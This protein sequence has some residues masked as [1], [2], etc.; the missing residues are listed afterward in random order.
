MTQTLSH[1]PV[2]VAAA[3]HHQI[4]PALQKIEVWCTTAIPTFRVVGLPGPEIIESCERVRAAIASTGIEFPKKRVIV[5]LS[6]AGIR[7]HGT[8]TDLAIALA[9]LLSKSA[10]RPK[11]LVVASGELGL[12]GQITSAGKITRTILAAL[13]AGA[14]D[15]LLALDDKNKAQTAA[16]LILKAHP[17]SLR[18]RTS[19]KPAEAP[20]WESALPRL[21]FVSSLSDAAKVIQRISHGE[22]IEMAEFSEPK[23]ASQ[24]SSHDL[25]RPSPSLL[26]KLLA[27][28]AGQHSILLLGPKGTGKTASL[29]WISAL[30]EDLGPSEEL[31]KALLHELLPEG[32]SQDPDSRSP[33]REVSPHARAE[34]L[35][36]SIRQGQV[37]PGELTLAHGGVLMADEFLEWRRDAR[38][39]LRDPIESGRLILQRGQQCVTLPARFQ[40]AGTANL[41]P[42]G[43]VPPE[44]SFRSHPANPTH[45]GSGNRCRCSPRHRQSY[46]ERLSGPILDRMDCIEWVHPASSQGTASR[47]EIDQIK[48]HIARIRSQLKENWGTL[49][50]RLSP[51]ELEAILARYPQLSQLQAQWGTPQCSLRRRHREIRVS[52]TLAA[53][54]GGTLPTEK[55]MSEARPSALE[56]LQKLYQGASATPIHFLSVSAPT[57]KT[58]GLTQTSPPP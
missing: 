53:L 51:T 41:C 9:V 42:C 27:C 29:S 30:R 55:Q 54:D 57:Q 6:P 2:L 32:W 44:F 49:P 24:D 39:A 35:L 36:G 47:T 50:G 14:S 1:S 56:G 43:G 37:L 23:G 15:L 4:E 11:G 40:F 5:N 45:H 20:G 7:K 10:L 58:Q 8:G 28:S 12:S 52:L 31:E 33:V 38:E 48:S 13:Q 18:S 34:A 3:L 25:L 21:W 22:V 16:Q 46:L 26:R 19:A 17:S